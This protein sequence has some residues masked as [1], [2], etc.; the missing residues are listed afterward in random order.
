MAKAG[1]KDRGLFEKLKGSGDW[2][3][4]FSDRFGKR[5][6]ERAG[7]KNRARALYEQRK[8][9]ERLARQSPELSVR[10]PATFEDV[11]NDA[12]AYCR[13]HADFSTDEERMK[14]ML[15]WWAPMP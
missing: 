10:R 11:A 6:R 14:R 12:L 2:W 15:G 13:R 9:E 8:Q 4:Q 1:S 7:A 3:I 5:R